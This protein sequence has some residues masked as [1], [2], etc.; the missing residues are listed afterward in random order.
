[1]V[2]RSIGLLFNIP[3]LGEIF[4]MTNA[5]PV[6]RKTIEHLLRSGAS[7]AIQPGG[8]KEQAQTRHDQE[9]AFFPA[10]LGFIRLAIQHGTP[11]L[12]LYLFGE[13][14]LYKRVNGFE[15][16]TKLVKKCTGMTIP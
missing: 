1:M 8:V 10:K 15:W 12:P 16:L 14:Q 13:N 3:M 4:S 6:D 5:R 9:Q 2:L 11:L 7:V